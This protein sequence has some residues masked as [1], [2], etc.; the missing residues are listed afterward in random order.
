MGMGFGEEEYFHKVNKEL[1]ERK[2]KQLD[3]LRGEQLNRFSS[4]LRQPFTAL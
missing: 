1:I 4:D 2:R 3:A